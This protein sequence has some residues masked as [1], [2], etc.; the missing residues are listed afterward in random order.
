MDISI[1]FEAVSIDFS[2]NDEEVNRLRMSNITQIY[3]SDSSF[4]NIDDVKL[5][6]IGINEERGALD[7][8]GCAEAPDEVRK[9][10]YKLFAHWNKLE[11]AD[12]GNIK[13][14]HT[15]DDTYFAVREVVSELLNKNI[16]PV[17]IG[18]SQDLTYANYLAYE[19]IGR[20]I[21]IAS[22]DPMFDLGHDEHELNTR[23][24]L[25]RIILHQPN[26]LFN[27]TN[28]GYQTYF[29]DQDSLVL[30]KNLYFDVN[31]LGNVRADLEESEPMIR[32][33]DIVSIDVSSIRAADAPA[34]KY[35]GP[36]GFTGEEVCR[37]CRY[38]G[39]SDK[40]SSIGFYELNPLYDIEGRS[41]QLVAQMIWYFLDGFVN[42]MDD[43]P[44]EDSENYIRFI[45]KIEDSEEDLI[46]LKS[47]K[48]D[49][50]WMDISAYG[51]MSRKYIKHQ[52]V[53]C[54]YIDYQQAL[55]NEIPDRW[56]KVQ[57]KLM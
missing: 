12:L 47:K 42:R 16:I 37:I 55:N 14:G 33:A 53:P 56:W 17:I 38:A 30:M 34:G 52:F 13:N 29:V 3:T 10:F 7:N 15:V 27:F 57:Q 49:R 8:K 46:F 35:A 11:I 54:S 31:R 50:W 20:V 51:K 1:Y 25:S 44:D 32:N 41:A 40:L 4:P 36:N 26:F 9:Q 45:V 5:A 23:S 28:I 48:S 21:N 39:M 18:G 43:H 2:T 19:N 24:W 22:V 6:I